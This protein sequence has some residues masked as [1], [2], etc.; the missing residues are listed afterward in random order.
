MICPKCN[1]VVDDRS[2]FCQNCGYRFP[3]EYVPPVNYIPTDVKDLNFGNKVEEENNKK[4]ENS[5]LVNNSRVEKMSIGKYIVF[6]IA[7]FCFALLLFLIIL[8]FCY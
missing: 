8:S 4:Y 7:G 3:K 1:Y 2:N 5:V 6:G